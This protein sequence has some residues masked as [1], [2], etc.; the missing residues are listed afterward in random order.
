MLGIFNDVYFKK[1]I[2]LPW[3]YTKRFELEGLKFIQMKDHA[4]LQGE[5]ITMEEKYKY[6]DD[7]YTKRK[8]TK[9]RIQPNLTQSIKVY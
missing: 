8:P 3:F 6:I 4:L 2:F 5:I 7:F 9:K 1:F